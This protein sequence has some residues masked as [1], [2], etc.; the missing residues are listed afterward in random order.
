VFRSGRYLVHKIDPAR[1]LGVIRVP[2]WDRLDDLA[3]FGPDE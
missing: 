1:P 2:D 3:S